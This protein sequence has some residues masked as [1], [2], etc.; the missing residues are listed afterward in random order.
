MV[1][2]ALLLLVA[3][4]FPVRP[5]SSVPVEVYFVRH[6]ETVSNATGHYN[7][8]SL[9]ELTAAGAAQATS[10]A[11]TL[12]HVAFD[13]AIVSPSLRAEKT[14]APTLREHHL[15]ATIW[16]EFN[17]C[18]TEHGAAR[19]KPAS[20][21]LGR[22]AR[23]TAP[24]SLAS[25]LRVDPSDNRLYAPANYADGL[26][27]VQVAA[28]RTRALL[29]HVQ[30]PRGVFRV[31]IVGHAAQGSRFLDSMLGRRPVGDI[32]LKNGVIV[33]LRAEPG[34]QFKL[35]RKIENPHK[36]GRIDPRMK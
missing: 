34:K 30:K 13:L 5:P 12:A 22:G 29:M 8:R 28:S 7:A 1:I 27:Q 19:R 23:V 24:S 14:A 26:L 10:V 36:S 16:P 20:A 17:E 6:G 32:E 2:H 9:N 4:A 21:H 18:C 35:V 3:A 33:I 15:I 25:L 31:L 11:T